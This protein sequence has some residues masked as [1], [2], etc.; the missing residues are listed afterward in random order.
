[1]AILRGEDIAVFIELDEGGE[2]GI[3]GGE[4]DRDKDGVG[5]QGLFLQGLGIAQ[6]NGAHRAF[7]EHLEGHAVGVDLDLFVCHHGIEQSL[8]SAEA[9][10]AVNEVH[11][12]AEV[13]QIECIFEGGAAAADDAGRLARE[14][15]AVAGGAIGNAH[16]QVAILARHLQFAA[17]GTIGDDDGARFELSSCGGGDLFMCAEVFQ[18]AHLVKDQLGSEGNCLLI[19]LF[20]QL[21]AADLLNGGVVF[22]L[23]CGQDLPAVHIGFENGDRESRPSG[24][25]R[26]RQP[27]RARADD[28]DICHGYVSFFL[29]FHPIIPQSFFDCNDQVTFFQNLFEVLRNPLTYG[30]IHSKIDDEKDRPRKGNVGMS[31][32]YDLKT[33]LPRLLPFWDALS[34]ADREMLLDR[35]RVQQFKKGEIIHNCSGACLGLVA[36]LRGNLCSCM[37]SEEGREI[38]LFPLY[39]NDLCVFGSACV[40]RPVTCHAH[41]TAEVDT[42]MLMIPHRAWEDLMRRNI[43]VECHAHK[44]AGRLLS[45]V[46]ST[47]QQMLFLDF[48]TRLAIHLAHEY[49]RTGSA[50]IRTTH[51]K[52]ARNIGSAREVVTRMLKK[53]SDA[54]LVEVRRGAVVILDP[55]G[56]KAM[57]PDTCE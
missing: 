21:P 44:I 47:M 13:G 56:L 32:P 38:T 11:L 39:E 54:G 12:F 27:C 22:D 31:H 48:D 17:L 8:L 29:T 20:G 50:R 15:G 49:D 37:L 16:A 2:D 51:E 6:A 36:V 35:T 46:L 52:I 25:N 1:M 33:E 4:A 14:E 18:T 30:A 7:A 5:R 43:T 45:N 9:L 57:L 3:I 26:R 55:D 40:L 24:I 42:D 10:A 28:Q 34:A 19:E 23:G 53:F 41:L